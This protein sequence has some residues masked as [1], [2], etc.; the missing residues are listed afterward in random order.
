MPGATVITL[1]GPFA[2]SA[3]FDML[4]TWQPVRHFA[5]ADG[6]GVL[7]FGLDGSFEPAG[8]IVREDGGQLTIEIGGTRATAAAV[9]QVSRMF[10]LDVD[11]TDYPLVGRRDP[12]IGRVMRAYPGLRPVLFPSPYEC[13]VWAVLSQRIAQ[14]Q[15]ARLKAALTA[16]HGEAVK[17]GPEEVRVLPSPEALLRV[18]SFAGVPAEKITRLHAVAR[19]ALEGVLDATHLRK[20]GHERAIETLQKIRGIG[21]F[22]SGGIYLRAAGVAEPFPIDE[23]RTLR[24]LADAHGLADAPTGVALARIVGRFKPFGMWVS[25][26]LRVA[27]NRGS[28][29]EPRG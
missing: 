2:W 11:A 6:T 20:L 9:A 25:V 5:R 3:S 14:T 26:L 1:Q 16:A 15:A 21:P 19:S 4:T 17:V 23:P 27:A 12:A 7:G 24:A 28:M 18:H 29:G 8:A 10:S 22:W 13:A